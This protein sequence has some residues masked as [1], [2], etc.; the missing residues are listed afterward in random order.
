L[1]FITVTELPV[2]ARKGP[3]QLHM[4]V[5]DSIGDTGCKELQVLD[6]LVGRVEN[7]VHEETLRQ[8]DNRNRIRKYDEFCCIVM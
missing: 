1:E 4:S 5:D 7:H 3:M 2:Q 8:Q 6:R